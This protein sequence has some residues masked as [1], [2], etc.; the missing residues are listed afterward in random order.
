MSEQNPYERLGVNE[1]SS[2][3]E[4]QAAKQRL[5]QQYKDNAQVIETIEASYDAVIMDRLRMRQ[6]G[7][8]KVPDRI[9]FPER[10]SEVSPTPPPLAAKKSPSW[11]QQLVDTPSQKDLLWAAAVFLIL[12]I[13]AIFAQN[14]RESVL[15]LL[16]AVGVCA[17]I[18]LVNRKEQRLGRAVLFTLGGLLL[19]MALATGLFSLLA[20]SN[21]TLSLSVEQLACLVTF[22]LFWLISSFLR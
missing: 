1:N 15:P 22:F 16:M 14:N 17:N 11:L 9:R 8:I 12:S 19:G 4:I 10:L 5:L 7:R 3:E 6:E 20:A 21:N 13:I 2:F 18:Y